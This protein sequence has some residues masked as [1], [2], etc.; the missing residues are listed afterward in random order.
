MILNTICTRPPREGWPELQEVRALLG[1]CPDLLAGQDAT[2]EWE[3]GMAL[4]AIQ[5]WGEAPL[6]KQ[7]L[8]ANGLPWKLVDIGGAQSNFCQ[9]LAYLGHVEVVDPA[10]HTPDGQSG[11][12]HGSEFN[13]SHAKYSV[14]EYAVGFPGR[15]NVLTCISVI[16][17]IPQKQIQEFLRALHRLLKP[18]GLLVLTTDYWD[19]EGPDTAHFHWMRERIYTPETLRYLRKKIREVGFDTFGETSL[20]WNGNIV[21]DYSL[22]HLSYV[23]R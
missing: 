23:K 20:A 17:H 5:A 21:Y 9:A 13:V 16:E 19:F 14:E 2:R 6:L 15:F 10:I 7:E 11:I 1:R 3:Y 12:T 4:K 22:V 8:G 18:G